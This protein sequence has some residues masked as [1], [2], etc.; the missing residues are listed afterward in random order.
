MELV[1]VVV[2]AA[3]KGLAAL[4]LVVVGTSLC[5]TGTDLAC[6]LKPAA[7]VS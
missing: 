5:R 6:C 7:W 3:T 1:V 2:V 4:S